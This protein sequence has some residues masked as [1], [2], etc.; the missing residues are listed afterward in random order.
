MSIDIFICKTEQSAQGT[1]F[2][3]LHKQTSSY[4]VYFQQ[5]KGVTPSF[6]KN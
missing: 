1:T 3:L 4:F 6:N 2:Y 5:S